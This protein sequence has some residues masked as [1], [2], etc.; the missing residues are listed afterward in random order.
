MMTATLATIAVSFSACTTSGSDSATRSPS[1]PWEKVSRT[2]RD[3]GQAT[4]R[5]R[6][7][8][9]SSRSPQVRA[10]LRRW[11]AAVLATLGHLPLHDVQG[12]D[13]EQRDDEHHGRERGRRRLVAALEVAEH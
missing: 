3:V 8:T 6:Y 12:D 2:T 4:S 9:T 13:R 7:P 1:S 11:P 5:N 10:E